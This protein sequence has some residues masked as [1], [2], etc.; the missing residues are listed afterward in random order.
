[1]L[2]A[3]LLL[4]IWAG[5]CGDK[6]KPQKK[7]K[8]YIAPVSLKGCQT[9]VLDNQVVRV[10]LNLQTVVTLKKKQE[11]INVHVV[12][13]ISPRDGGRHEFR[14]T[15]RTSKVSSD[16][17]NDGPDTLAGSGRFAIIMSEGLVVVAQ[18]GKPHRYESTHPSSD[19]GPGLR[20]GQSVVMTAK[21]DWTIPASGQR[22]N[23]DLTTVHVTLPNLGCPKVRFSSQ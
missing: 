7:V 21:V 14:I 5:G 23:L 9:R 13:S 12:H 20:R 6:A 15:R 3:F 18:P 2:P 11:G 19:P 10:R 1:M 8:R 4:G 17:M 22:T 16:P